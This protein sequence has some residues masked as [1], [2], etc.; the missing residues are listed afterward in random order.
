MHV[1]ILAG[2]R[3]E[4]LWPLSSKKNPKPF[5]TIENRLPLLQTTF[6]LI[7]SLPGVTR[8]Y[9]ISHLSHEALIQKTLKDKKFETVLEQESLGTFQAIYLALQSVDDDEPILVMPSDHHIEDDTSFQMSL[10][11]ARV[12]A[13]LDKIALLASEPLYPH[14]GYGYIKTGTGNCI[15]AFYEKPTFEK[16]AEFLRDSGYLW[17][18]GI[19]CFKKSVFLKEVQKMQCEN[20]TLSVDKA[21]LEHSKN[22]MFVK[23]DFLWADMGIWD[24][25]YLTAKKDSQNNALTGSVNMINS[26]N[27]LVIGGSR[28]ISIID[29]DDIYVIDSDDGL[30]I[31]KKGS[32]QK[33]REI[34]NSKDGDNL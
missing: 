5:V 6:Q 29:L 24:N 4:R 30:L 2:G 11:Q 22:L 18:T 34:F 16:A 7:E 10:S 9:V 8:I 12:F 32:S 1:F 27:A 31:G 23:I 25:Y 3:G 33:V 15:R 19:M 13:D 28:K 14:C 26:K 21:V 20:S 17:N